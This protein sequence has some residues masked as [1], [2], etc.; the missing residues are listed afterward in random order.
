MPSPGQQYVKIYQAEMIQHG[1]D[2]AMILPGPAQTLIYQ[3]PV[4]WPACIGRISCPE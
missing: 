1:S 3:V 4:F 2:M